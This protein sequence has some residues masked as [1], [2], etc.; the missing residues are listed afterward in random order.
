MLGVRIGQVCKSANILL[1]YQTDIIPTTTKKSTRNKPNEAACRGV[2]L[3]GTRNSSSTASN[4]RT[5]LQI[6][7]TITT[8]RARGQ[9]ELDCD[10][11]II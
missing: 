9:P 2:R 7:L 11:V 5:P 10:Q 6:P 8:Y 3:L 4:T 1:L